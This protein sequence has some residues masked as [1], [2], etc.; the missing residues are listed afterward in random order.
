MVQSSVQNDEH[1]LDGQYRSLQC[2]LQPLDSNSNEYKVRYG[3]LKNNII[4]I[5]E[6]WWMVDVKNLTS[7]FK[8]AVLDTNC[9]SL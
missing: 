4:L 2:R 3:I 9:L 5:V 8:Y 1:P 7:L 6:F